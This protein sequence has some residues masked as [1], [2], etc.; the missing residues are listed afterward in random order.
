MKELIMMNE[1]PN[2][3]IRWV[4]YKILVIKS[5][6]TNLANYRTSVNCT[7]TSLWKTSKLDPKEYTERLWYIHG[8]IKQKSHLKNIYYIH[9]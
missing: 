7:L 9:S 3:K 2:Q 6:F 4:D 1:I 8:L 5:Y